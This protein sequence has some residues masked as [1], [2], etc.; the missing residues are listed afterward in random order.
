MITKSQFLPANA[1]KLPVYDKLLLAYGLKKL[2]LSKQS[3][4]LTKSIDHDQLS[5]QKEALLLLTISDNDKSSNVKKISDKFRLSNLNIENLKD[6]HENFYPLLYKYSSV[7]NSD[8]KEMFRR[9]SDGFSP[10]F[11][12]F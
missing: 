3:R 8:H 11:N 9:M 5:N 2:D 1:L 7:T 4:E 10:F 6:F 12:I